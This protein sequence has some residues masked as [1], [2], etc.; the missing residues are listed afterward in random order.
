[1]LA[2]ACASGAATYSV[3]SIIS[4]PCMVMRMQFIRIVKMTNK[5]NIGFTKIYK[6]IFLIEW[7]GPNK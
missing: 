4:L 5:L 6:T 3:F 2:S 7:N 1:M